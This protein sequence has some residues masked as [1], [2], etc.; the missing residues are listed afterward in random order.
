LKADPSSADST[1]L[2]K[3]L[4]VALL[5]AGL[6]LSTVV[7]YLAFMTA[8]DFR[9]PALLELEIRNN[10]AAILGKGT[11]FSVLSFNIGY[12][13]MDA[14]A[15]FFMDG[16]RG[17]RSASLQQ[18]QTNLRRIAAFLAAEPADLVLLQEVD[19]RASRSY[20][21]DELDELE[22]RLAGHGGIFALNYKGPWVPVPLA[23]P[24]G[25]VESC[26]LTFSRLRVNSARRFRLPGK[27]AWP[28]Q[29]AELDRCVS[30]CRL[31]LKEGGELVLLNLH[32]SAFDRGGRIRRQQLTWLRERLLA[33][34]KNGSH[35]IAGGDWNHGLPGS[36][37][38]RFPATMAP[39]A[40][41]MALPPGFTP[42]GFVWALDP[43]RPTVRA[44]STPYRP[45]ENFV[46]VIDGFLVSDN[47]AVRQVSVRDLDFA[48]S[49]HNPVRAVFLLK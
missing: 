41:Y 18:T 4:T 3:L 15:D 11:P 21:V 49:D 25:A 16:G 39:S 45:G 22:K 33:E 32:L 24:M 23:R 42:P 17:S 8:T 5:A 43:T 31:P 44:S 40:W 20:R 10:T 37:P 19:R 46:A 12:C 29:L 47:V 34:Y 27:E 2:A 38:E 13:G 28:R 30:E 1:L 7:L 26:L 48:N 6:L 35:V 36:D 9:P 14:G